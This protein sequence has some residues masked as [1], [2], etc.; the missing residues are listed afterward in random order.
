[1]P[2]LLAVDCLLI[3]LAL[4]YIAV[5]GGA[6]L[7]I[8]LGI[9]ASGSV[10]Y[11]YFRIRTHRILTS[12][13]VSKTSAPFFAWLEYLAHLFAMW[14]VVFAA[15]GAGEG[16]VRVASVIVMIS[17]PIIVLVTILNYVFGRLVMWAERS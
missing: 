6:E 9:L 10:A 4:F 14:L 3:V 1:M 15:F 17:I 13:V 5:D 16:F 8:V 7:L 2:K 12:Q 11:H